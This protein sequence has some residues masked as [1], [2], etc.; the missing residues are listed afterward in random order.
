MSLSVR[1]A[2]ISLARQIPFKKINII[3]TILGGGSSLSL[4]SDF[5]SAVLT[6][7]IDCERFCII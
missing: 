4:T 3:V 7:G 6:N 2:R 5:R 1:K